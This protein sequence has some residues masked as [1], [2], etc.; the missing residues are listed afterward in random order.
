MTDELLAAEKART[1]NAAL[2]EG[3]N[4]IVAS[5]RGPVNFQRGEDG[6]L[7]WQRSGGGLVTALLGLA[8]STEMTWVASKEC[9]PSSKKPSSRPTS[10]RSSTSAQMCARHCCKGVSAGR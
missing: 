4:L 3:L 2:L 10:V 5:N 9:P 6:S 8:H 1:D 7:A